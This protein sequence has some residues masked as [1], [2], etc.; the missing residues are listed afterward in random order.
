MP[1]TRVVELGVVVE[2]PEGATK[3]QIIALAKKQK[4]AVKP[5]PAAAP[6]APPDVVGRAHKALTAEPPMGART[7]L[8]RKLFGEKIG[9]FDTPGRVV[10]AAGDLFLP[11]SVPEAVALG[12][13]LPIGGGNVV[14]Q[15]LKRMGAAALAG[16]GA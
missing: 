10:R 5:T 1:K 13:T 16:G 9:S 6:P 12:A 4:A 3:E 11:S 8:S 7:E 15:P 14:T 2:H